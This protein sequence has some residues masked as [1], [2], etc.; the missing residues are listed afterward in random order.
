MSRA[1]AAA[2][3]PLLAALI[4]KLPAPGG[5]FGAAERLSWL[6]LAVLAFEVSYGPE[7]A[8]QVSGEQGGQ[9]AR[10]PSEAFFGGPRGGS[11]A[12]VGAIAPGLRLVNLDAEVRY[13]VDPDGRALKDPGA[14]PIM[15][16]DVPRDETLW[17]ERPGGLRDLDTITWGDGQQ[18]PAGALP[19]LNIAS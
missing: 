7:V 3:D 8:I 14:L 16:H 19:S 17:D 2:M 15:P 6:R 4:G 12:E 18:W 9:D 11:M 13:Y 5:T 10:G 1:K